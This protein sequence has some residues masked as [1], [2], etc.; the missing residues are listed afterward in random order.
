[1]TGY[2][3]DLGRLEAVVS[4]LE[5]Q[6]KELKEQVAELHKDLQEIKD[7]IAQIRGGSRVV[8]WIGGIVSGAGGAALFKFLPLIFPR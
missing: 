7:L 4:S 2:E 6:N 1:M 3:R 8:F 5:A